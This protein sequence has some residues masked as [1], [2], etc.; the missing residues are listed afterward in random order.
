[1]VGLRGG[2]IGEIFLEHIAAAREMSALEPQISH[3]AQIVIEALRGGGRVLICGNGG[4]AADAQHISA[5]FTGR[6]SRERR[7]LDVQ[8]LSTNTSTL[9]AIGNDF[10]MVETFARQVLA[11]GRRDD[12]LIAIST[13]GNSA[14]VLRAVEAARQVGMSVIGLSGRTGGK[15]APICDVCLCAPTDN[16]QRIQEMHILVG[17]ILCELAEG[18]LCSTK[19]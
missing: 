18:T 7:P 10:T 15:L 9:T 8:A 16:T 3:A 5:E 13:S 17:H 2:A 6:L 11:H 4:S 12:A 1:M 19:P 14:N